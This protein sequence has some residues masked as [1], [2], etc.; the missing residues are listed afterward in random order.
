MRTILK[1]FNNLS[2][3]IL[4]SLNEKTLLIL[5]IMAAGIRLK[6]KRVSI[7]YPEKGVLLLHPI[8][9]FAWC[10]YERMVQEWPKR[11]A[12]KGNPESPGAFILDPPGKSIS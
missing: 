8:G 5:I 2:T 10:F 1:D 4:I 12:P 7:R 9:L 6:P 3:L 11:K